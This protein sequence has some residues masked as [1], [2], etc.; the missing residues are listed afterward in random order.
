MFNRDTRIAP[1]PLPNVAASPRTDY[2]DPPSSVSN[3]S[4]ARYGAPAHRPSDVDP[5]ADISNYGEHLTLKTKGSLL[6]QGLIEGDVKGE[7]VTVDNERQ[8]QGH[9]HGPHHCDQGRRA[10]CAQ[11][12]E[13]HP[14]RDPTVD[15]DITQQN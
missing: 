4:D 5:R 2:P 12:L 14:A 11:G 10:G 9:D 8:R 3:A 7:L 6:I 13:R 1:P 15:A